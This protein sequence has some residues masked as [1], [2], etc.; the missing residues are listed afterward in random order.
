MYKMNETVLSVVYCS[1]NMKTM[2]RRFGLAKGRAKES[3]RRESHAC[4]QC[5]LDLRSTPRSRVTRNTYGAA[6]RMHLWHGCNRA[7]SSSSLSID[8]RVT[9]F[10][11]TLLE[12]PPCCRAWRISRATGPHAVAN[13]QRQQGLRLATHMWPVYSS[14]GQWPHSKSAHAWRARNQDLR[15]DDT[16]VAR[17][18]GHPLE[19]VTA[20]PSDRTWR[21]SC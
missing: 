3:H 4:K 5:N 18:N 1:V 19:G 9:G 12:T 11:S 20:E 14:C 21:D 7:I 10:T 16:D 15:S 8:P 17:Y 6:A 13:M 2:D